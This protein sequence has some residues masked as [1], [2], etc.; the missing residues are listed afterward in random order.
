M[1][2]GIDRMKGWRNAMIDY[3]ASYL[4]QSQIPNP[5]TFGMN[6][7]FAPSSY[8]DVGRGVMNA[9][10]PEPEDTMLP[11]AFGAKGYSHRLAEMMAER[12]LPEGLVNKTLSFAKDKEKYYK[13]V[14][15]RTENA[16]NQIDPE[17]YKYM[18]GPVWDETINY[19]GY[20]PGQTYG[21]Y[22]SLFV[23]P[24]GMNEIMKVHKYAPEYISKHE[25]GH[26]VEYLLDP[27]QLYE[28]TK[29]LNDIMEQIY[30]AKFKGNYNKIDL[31][32]QSL[33]KQYEGLLPI[34]YERPEYWTRK[35]TIGG[36]GEYYPELI[37]DAVGLYR[38]PIFDK[39][40]VNPKYLIELL[41]K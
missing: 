15:Q 19:A 4:P 1:Y 11:V 29:P 35:P 21:N 40:P 7:V 10:I 23:N 22:G 41:G 18:L 39:L 36:H 12:E 3:L 14:Q 24:K 9:L 34:E 25:I 16:L 27:L 30:E 28:T 2:P 26:G 37:A 6:A 32:K 8:Q 38:T 5:P 31:I 17:T 13:N 33:K 20:M